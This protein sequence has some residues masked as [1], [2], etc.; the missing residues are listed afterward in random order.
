MDIKKKNL[1]VKKEIEI[2]DLKNKAMLSQKI[3][4]MFNNLMM[5]NMN[6]K[7]NN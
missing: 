6:Q 7:F 1:K 2:N 4:F 5:M 3:I